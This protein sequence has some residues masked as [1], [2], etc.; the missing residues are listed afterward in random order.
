M[1]MSQLENTK[2][3]ILRF[4]DKDG[5]GKIDMEELAMCLGVYKGL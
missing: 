3:S 1:D 4:F 5:D 2:Q